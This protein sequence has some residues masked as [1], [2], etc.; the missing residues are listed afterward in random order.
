LIYGGCQYLILMDGE[1]SGE[2]M[3]LIHGGCQYL[4]LMD[5]ESSGKVMSLTQVS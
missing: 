5:G 1:S 3:S 2:V 4:I